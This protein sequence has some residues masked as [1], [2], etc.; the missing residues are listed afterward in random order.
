[1]SRLLAEAIAFY[2]Y[3]RILEDIGEFAR[4]V[5]DDDLSE[6]SRQEQITLLASFFEPGSML[7]EVERVRIAP[8]T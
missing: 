3:E 6:A 8:W 4:S 7:D 2:R 5:R 1:M